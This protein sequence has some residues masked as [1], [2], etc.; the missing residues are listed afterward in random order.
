MAERLAAV[1]LLDPIKWVFDSPYVQIHGSGYEGFVCLF[2]AVPHNEFATMGVLGDLGEPL[3]PLVFC[4]RRYGSQF[5]DRSILLEAVAELSEAIVMRQ[6]L[7]M[8]PELKLE[9]GILTADGQKLCEN[10]LLGLSEVEEPVPLAVV[11]VG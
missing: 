10:I 5:D 1:D 2:K 3:N 6:G 8:R 7:T 11:G 4:P 9:Y